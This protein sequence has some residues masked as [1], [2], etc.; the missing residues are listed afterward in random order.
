M[1]ELTTKT[2]TADSRMGSHS[3]TSGVMK[4]SLG[5]TSLFIRLQSSLLEQRPY[6]RIPP[7]EV[8]VQRAH[9]A[10]PAAR[11]N[12]IAEALAVGPCH[13]PV[14]GEPGVGVVIEHLAPHVRVVA[15]V[16]PA[17]PDVREVGSAIAWRHFGH[18]HAEPPERL[19]I[20]RASC[21]ERV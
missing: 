16:V 14:L 7:P 18:V 9:V 21:R 19:E 1:R 17:V 12:H 15:G 11:Q 8:A 13:A 2:P 10:R 20:G 6:L 3:E 5:R 4:T